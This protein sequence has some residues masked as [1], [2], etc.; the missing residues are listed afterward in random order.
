MQMV[1]N[2][3]PIDLKKDITHHQGLQNFL[4]SSGFVILFYLIYTRHPYFAAYF[5]AN[6]DLMGVNFYIPTVFYLIS[7]I[8]LIC[9]YKINLTQEVSHPSKSVLAVNALIKLPQ[10]KIITRS[11][12]IALLTIILK[13]FFAPLMVKWFFGHTSEMLKHLNELIKHSDLILTNFRLIY[14]QHIFYFLLKTILFFDVI[15]FTL[16]Y[17]IDHPKYDNEIKSVEPTALGWFVALICYPP[18]NEVTHKILPWYSSDFPFFTDPIAFYT[19]SFL[20]LICMGLYSWASWSLGLKASNLTYRGFV[21]KG[22]YAFVRH[23]AY[24]FK[25][26]AW[27]LGAIP[28]ILNN[29]DK[30]L[31]EGLFALFC[32]SSWTYIYYLRAKTEERHLLSVCP[33][34]REYKKF[35]PAFIPKIH[36]YKTINKTL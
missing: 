6:Y 29:F 14:Q 7:L 13:A 32:L 11:E 18:F 24:F 12:K 5:K 10:G 15:F 26:M 16:G 28:A 21:D 33:Q 2:I 36:R 19:C 17:L 1:K 35:V 25:N 22:I 4:Y 3:Y 34:Y 23:P 9:L 20:V 8:Y 31:S 30:S 27:W